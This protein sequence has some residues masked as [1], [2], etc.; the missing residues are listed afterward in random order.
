MLGV[1]PE[2]VE[3]FGVDASA[4]SRALTALANAGLITVEVAGDDFRL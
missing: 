3:A 1:T 2:N 4:K